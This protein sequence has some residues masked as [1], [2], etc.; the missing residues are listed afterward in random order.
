MHDL[1]QLEGVPQVVQQHQER[2]EPM[3]A[4]LQ[5]VQEEVV[6][7]HLELQWHNTYPE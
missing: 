1:Q 6:E 3:M 7:W 2:R 4:V 5:E